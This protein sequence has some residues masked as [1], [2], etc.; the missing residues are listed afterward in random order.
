[1]RRKC[2]IVAGGAGFVGSHLCRRLLDEGYEVDCIDSL[3]TGRRDNIDSLDTRGPFR[4]HHEDV[5]RPIRF[6]HNADAVFHLASPAS[7]ADYLRHPLETL[8]AG[9]A[10]T[11]NTLELAR[12]KGARY[13]LASTSEVY[14]N[15]QVHPQPETY[16]GNV[17]PVGPRSA[18]DE[19]KRFA[20]ALVTAHRATH[21]TSTAIARVFNTY[22]PRMRRTDGRAVPAFITQALDGRPLTVTGTGSQT[23]SLRYVDDLVEGLLALHTSTV[24][25]PLNLGNPEEITVLELARQILRA[26]GSGS[27]TVFVNRPQDDPD[28]RCPDITRAREELGWAPKTGLREGLDRTIAWYRA[29]RRTFSHDAP[30]WT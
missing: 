25:G 20:E 12:E 30:A 21:G 2:A 13:I 6:D 3:L 23:R 19:A 17:N 8:T 24:P 22:G 28:R 11:A 5:A 26:T 1:M 9:S 29:H 4:F 16:W 15:P 10:G 18:Y 14:G 7:P 27:P